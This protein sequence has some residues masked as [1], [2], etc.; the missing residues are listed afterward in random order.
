M[1][2]LRLCGVADPL[3]VALNN[4]LMLCYDWL[5]PGRL[6]S[7]LA[8]QRCMRLS[9]SGVYTQFA[10]YVAHYPAEKL[11]GRLLYLEHRSLQQLLVADKRVARQ[12]WRLEL[13]LPVNKRAA[14]EPAIISIG[15]VAASTDQQFSSLPQL[16]GAADLAAFQEGLLDLPA[17]RQL[18]AEAEAEVA[19]L[20]SQLPSELQPGA[21][22]RRSRRRKR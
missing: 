17:W 8:L 19:L 10:G 7:Q 1:A 11:A 14:G 9:A 5:T 22:Q 16:P 3:A 18:A 2:V 4:V 6:I 15:D 13:G 21:G 12:A 20:R